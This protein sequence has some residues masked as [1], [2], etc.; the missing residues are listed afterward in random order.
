M[1]TQT[2]VTFRLVRR[3]ISIQVDI[4]GTYTVAVASRAEAWIE[5]KLSIEQQLNT[6]RVA[7]RAEAWIETR[8]E[9]G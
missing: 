9:R 4:S 8:S 5:T 3:M 7:S 1:P 2:L 6:E